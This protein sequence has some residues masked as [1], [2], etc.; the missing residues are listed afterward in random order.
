[1]TLVLFE[2]M[3]ALEVKATKEGIVPLQ[4]EKYVMSTKD[5]KIHSTVLGINRVLNSSPCKKLYAKA[6]NLKLQ[7]FGK[8]KI[9]YE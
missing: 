2:K 7:L 1:M 6:T 9:E 5:N 8:G 4:L 3:F